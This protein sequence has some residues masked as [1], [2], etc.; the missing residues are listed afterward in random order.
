MIKSFG[1]RATEDIYHGRES[2]RARGT[3]PKELWPIAVRRLD[4]LDA[5]NDLRDLSAP[6]LRLEPLKGSLTGLWSIRIN[7]QYRLV[8]QW[9]RGDAYRVGITDYH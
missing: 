1:D 7:D 4:M 6:G 9:E 3:L 5:A 2:K 8:F